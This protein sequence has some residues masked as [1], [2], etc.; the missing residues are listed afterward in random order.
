[1]KRVLA[2]F[3]KFLIL[4]LGVLLVFPA[5][6]PSASASEFPDLI[7]EWHG[8]YRTL[9]YHDEAAHT[10]DA[11]MVLTISRQEN[12][13]VFATH[14][15]ELHEDN[16][17][18]PDMAGEAVR[19]GAETLIGAV[20]FNGKDMTLLETHDN[21]VF[22]LEVVGDNV[23]QGRYHEQGHHE[24]TVFRVRLTREK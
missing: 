22:E 21:G 13:L 11:T 24:A 2:Q 20:G 7:G 18:K 5:M 4:P 10:G 12:E 16:P 6:G 17:G 9:V 23:M 1:M 19:G 15:W 8:T 14:K 3:A